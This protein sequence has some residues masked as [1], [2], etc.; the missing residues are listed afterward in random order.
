MTQENHIRPE[1]L[2]NI[3][4]QANLNAL[5]L[6]LYQST[7]D[8]D[9]ANMR[10]RKVPIRGGAMI[11]YELDPRDHEQVKAKAIEFFSG[12]S[13]RTSYGPPSR[14]EERL[15]MDM[16]TGDSLSDLEYN[17]GREELALDPFPREASWTKDRVDIPQDFE[18]AVLGAGASGIAMAV[19]LERLGIP[20]RIYER[21]SRLGGT[22][23]LNTYPDLRVDTTSFLYQFK[24]VKNYAWSEY[25]A[26]QAE[27]RA[28]LEEIADKYDVLKNI[29]FDLELI[30]A[31][32]DD[33]T[34]TWKMEFKDEGGGQIS[35]NANVIVSGVGLFNT[36]KVPLFEGLEKFQGS[37]IHS[38][39]WD[40]T[41]EIRDKAI[42]IVGNGSTGVQL[43]PR[44]AEVA[45][46]LYVFQR[47]PQW[48]SPM[49][50]Y[51]KRISAQVRWLFDHVPYYWN[52]YCYSA[53]ITLQGLQDCQEYDR[54]WQTAG[55]MISERNDGLRTALTEYIRSELGDPE[56]V[57]KV[58]PDYAP[59]ARRLVVDNG[60]YASLTRDNVHLVTEGIKN[61]TEHGIN[62][63]SGT[64]IPL[65]VVVV[66]TGFDVSKYLWPTNY[67]G[68]DGTSIRD[69]WSKDGPRAYLGL[70][71]PEFPNLFILYGPNAQIRSGAFVSWI[72]IWSRYV[73][74]GIVY[75]LENNLQSIE[76][77]RDVF[78]RY[79]DT[80]DAAQENLI[81]DKEGPTARN[82]YVNEFGRQNI[83]VPFRNE[84]YFEMVKRFNPEDF[85]AVQSWHLT[86]KPNL[87][88]TERPYGQ[89]V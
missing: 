15:M 83:Q 86:D 61:F 32:F 55:G 60:W 63:S 81:W 34:G 19:Q 66:A 67:F 50:N 53:F 26:S 1:E 5:R 25:F 27:V 41:V 8:P 45:T 54:A 72:E 89:R 36:P 40:D 82:Y 64:E 58:L 7:H 42:A 44:L 71:V 65:E 46:D 33:R 10:V 22:W 77:R 47:T 20:Y 73:A 51:K 59:L 68:I 12:S 43:M 13:M 37:I 16:L 48:I 29:E 79:N 84:D 74:Q 2:L 14:S 3:L 18:V 75:M 28:Y 4:D 35:R 49:P 76:V 56:I 39:E 6:A 80:L 23:N 78:D 30:E 57:A 24:F 17:L 21:Q 38:T 70:A 85:T 9:L 87:S 88:R 69:A 11:S 52:W 31:T 62:T